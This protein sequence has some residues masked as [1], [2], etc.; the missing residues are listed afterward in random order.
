MGTGPIFFIEG[1]SKWGQ[2]PFF[3]ELEIP[4]FY[5]YSFLPFPLFLSFPRK[6]ESR[7]IWIRA[8]CISG[9]T[10]QRENTWI[11]A[12]AG[13][14]FLKMLPACAGTSTCLRRHKPR[15]NDNFIAE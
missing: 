11:P 14:T 6:R 15:G 12:F 7:N 3:L 10:L 2:A 13:M 5:H 1:N 8:F 4:P 9:F